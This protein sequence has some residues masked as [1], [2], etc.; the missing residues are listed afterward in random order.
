MEIIIDTTVL[1][2]FWR[3]AKQPERL[4]DMRAKAAEAS[5][6]ISWIVEAEFLRGSIRQGLNE[7]AVNRFFS[8]FVRVP[9]ADSWI[10]IYARTWAVMKAK[11]LNPGYPDLWL[12]AVALDRDC[13]LLTR[14]S[15]HFKDIP[16]LKVLDYRLI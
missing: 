6:G 13:P 8:K 14:N 7:E 3:C 10:R 9:F 12:A 15:G 5:L 11:N 4:A 16:E 2:D 1:I